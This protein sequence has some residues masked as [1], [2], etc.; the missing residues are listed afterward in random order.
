MLIKG[1]QKLTLLDFPEKVACTVFTGGCNFRCPFCHNASLVTSQN[2]DIIEED[3]FFSYLEKRKNMLEGVCVSGGE[4]TIQ[5]DIYDFIRKIKEMG[6][7]VKL[8]TNGYRPDVLK[9]L[10]DDSLVD[11][12]AMDIKNSPEKYAVTVGLENMDI[13][14][15]RQSAE[16]LMNGNVQ[17]EFRTTVVG[18]L[19]KKADFEAIGK[20][21]MGGERYF[22][23]SFIDSG[24]LI[25]DGFSPC[26]DS[27]M[28]DFLG[29]I[30]HYIPNAVIRGK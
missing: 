3:E 20:W 30:V 8:D 26:S 24:D 6:Y 4:P 2:D 9:N 7:A 10:C 27:E 18:E 13:E 14:K 29:T 25:K 11:Y 23:Q 15:I 28:N 12:V 22:L 21:L 5:P 16:F 1:L 19:H 17:F